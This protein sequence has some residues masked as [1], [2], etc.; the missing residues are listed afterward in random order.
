MLTRRTREFEIKGIATNEDGTFHARATLK[1]GLDT[2]SF[3]QVLSEQ[4]PCQ[5]YLLCNGE[6]ALWPAGELTLTLITG[7][8]FRLS[9]ALSAGPDAERFLELSDK[10]FLYV[11]TKRVNE[12]LSGE[13]LEGVSICL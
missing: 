5:F 7:K 8:T 12:D 6:L 3:E 9:G 13:K 11:K 1:T 10:S 2:P 4:M